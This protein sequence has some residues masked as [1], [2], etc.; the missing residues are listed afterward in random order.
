MIRHSHIRIGRCDG[1]ILSTHGLGFRFGFRSGLHE[2]SLDDVGV[3]VDDLYDHE[4]A[5]SA[6]I[7]LFKHE[8][9]RQG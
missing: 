8:Q 9:P 3:D 4:H 6:I 5:S 2:T 1:P 7:Y